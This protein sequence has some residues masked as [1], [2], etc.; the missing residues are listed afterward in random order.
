MNIVFEP[1]PEGTT[2]F[3]RYASG[4]VVWCK[5]EAGQNNRPI[6]SE[7]DSGN[8]YWVPGIHPVEFY[9]LNMGLASIEDF[10]TEPES[11]VPETGPVGA[12]H[13][14]HHGGETSWYRE[15]EGNLF[16]WRDGSWY[17]ST[18]ESASDLAKVCPLGAV[19]AIASDS[20][21]AGEADNLTWL[22]RNVHVWPA[23][24]H[25]DWCYVGHGY[26]DLVLVARAG[27][28]GM[29]ATDRERITRQQW[30]TRRAALQNKPS[31]EDAPEWA[32]WLA[33]D[34]DSVW[35]WH[36]KDPSTKGEDVSGSKYWLSHGS[37][38][39]ACG[40]GEILGSWR[41]T[42]E[43]RPK[44]L[45]EPAVTARL[46]EPTDNVLAAAPELMSD[47]FKFE[48]FTSTEDNQEQGMQQENGWFERGELLPPV[49]EWCEASC[50]GANPEKCKILA[51]H[52]KQVAV[53]WG[54]FNQ[55]CLDVLEMPGWE[56]RPIRT[57]HDHLMS[58]LAEF[59]GSPGSAG[60]IA[61]AILTD[62]FKRDG[63]EA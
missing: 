34:E 6:L 45:S 50:E 36:Q 56:F 28:T 7:W 31:W 12:T 26:H 24:D 53:Q 21:Q 58:I 13:C 35:Y 44:D 37:S 23:G 9:Q 62:G 46:K 63:G 14:Y 40:G 11:P 54:K 49:G 52:K 1:A 8:E 22:A 4:Y 43:R 20:P 18:Q 48:L 10:P 17:A 16:V 25:Q 59:D 32:E 5:V 33:Q 38:D 41:D 60:R 55:G 51:Y 47:K 29:A 57:E 15:A 19:I 61:D 39:I 3:L 2:H 27:P 30:L 42:L